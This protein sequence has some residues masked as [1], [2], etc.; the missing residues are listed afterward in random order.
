VSADSF[1]HFFFRPLAPLTLS[2]RLD[3]ESQMQ[4]RVHRKRWFQALLLAA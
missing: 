2:R 1:K 4:L 3:C